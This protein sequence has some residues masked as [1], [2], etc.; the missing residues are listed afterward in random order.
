L[1]S[2]G[3]C[4][5]VRCLH[6]SGGHQPYL[7][8]GLAQQGCDLAGG[9]YL[10]SVGKCGALSR[11]HSTVTCV[12]AHPHSRTYTVLRN[13]EGELCPP[14]KET[15]PDLHLIVEVKVIRP[16]MGHVPSR[17]FAHLPAKA[18]VR[19]PKIPP[20]SFVHNTLT[21][22]HNALYGLRAFPCISNKTRILRGGW[23][24]HPM[25]S[26]ATKRFG[27]V[28]VQKVNAYA[29][30]ENAH[31][32]GSELFRRACGDGRGRGWRA[33]VTRRWKGPPAVSRWRRQF[34]AP[35]PRPV[36]RCLRRSRADGLP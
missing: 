10:P 16:V 5:V 15:R 4:G 24:G 35:A 13:D 22:N 25:S 8:G 30:R 2:V 17:F 9:P 7:F 33:A 23:G 31:A 3:K 1:P 18:C 28:H 11:S 12:L 14:R 19:P 21:Y 32:D 26:L 20:N 36:P 6:L 29:R 34:P 27:K